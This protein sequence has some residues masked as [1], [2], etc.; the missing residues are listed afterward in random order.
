[1][2]PSDLG[3]ASPDKHH[4]IGNVEDTDLDVLVI[5]LHPPA[6]HRRS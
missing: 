3:I 2:G 1:M 4:G 5:D 6:S